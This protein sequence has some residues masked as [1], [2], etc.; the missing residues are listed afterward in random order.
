[1][2]TAKIISKSTNSISLNKTPYEGL[3]KKIPSVVNQTVAFE[4]R[5][6]N[7]ALANAIRRTLMSEMPIKHLTVSLADI[8]TTDPYIV[9]ELIRKRIE[10]IPISQSI[11]E[12]SAFAILFE[13]K[14]DE[15]IDVMSS[16]IKLNGVSSS[17]DITPFIPIC[18]INSGTSFS[19]NDIR[20]IESYGYSNSRVSIGRVAYEIID[21]DM[22]LPSNTSYPTSFRLEVETPGVINPVE[23]VKKAIECLSHRLDAIDFSA[24]VIEFDIYKLTI[25]NET[26]SIGRL[27]SWYIFHL[28]PTIK[29]VASRVPHPSTRECV[30]DIHHPKAEELCKKAIDM[31][32]SE[33]KSLAKVFSS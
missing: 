8:K 32:Q 12:D 2:P 3:S 19:V 33:L 25:R 15:Y 30:I 4:L 16:E 31:I 22:N 27:L 26:H 5:D 13:N 21:H 29:Y 18:D 24:A 7:C 17:K 6:A 20:V 10:M 9:G 14:E 28:N 23:M 1:M 11:N